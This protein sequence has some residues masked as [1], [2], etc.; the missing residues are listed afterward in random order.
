MKRSSM[1]VAV[2]A[3]FLLAASASAQMPGAGGHEHGTA[4]TREQMK[5]TEAA[6]PGNVV[7]AGNKSCPITGEPVSGKDF[8]TYEG[9]RYGL[10]C[11]SCDKMFLKDPNKYIQKLREKGEIK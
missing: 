11:K 1:W 9:V 3:I 5:Q 8:V 2:A 7:D 6:T 10:C 4:A